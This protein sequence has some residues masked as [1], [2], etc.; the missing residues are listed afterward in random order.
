MVDFWHDGKWNN[1]NVVQCPNSHN[2]VV[3]HN[4]FTDEQCDNIVNE[5][6]KWTSYEGTVFDSDEAQIHTD[7]RRVNVYEPPKSFDWLKDFLWSTL[8]KA[9]SDNWKFE[10][11]GIGEPPI[12]LEY[13]SP[14]AKYIWHMDLGKK[15]P[16]TNR[17]ILFVVLLNDEFEGGDLNIFFGGCNNQ[18]MPLK[19]GS[20][21]MFPSYTLHEV[22]EVLKGTRYT[23]AGWAGG[24]TFR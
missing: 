23:L 19:K 16:S 5:R 22:E 13:I 7:I 10:L 3:I 11:E 8:Q 18:T 1:K 24:N 17:K 20:I 2:W 4:Y 15:G 6:V 14:G 21:V 9:N 12:L